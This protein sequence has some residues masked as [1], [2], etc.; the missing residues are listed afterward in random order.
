MER[1]L[2][3][4][5]SLTRDQREAVGLLQ[6]GTLLEY[7]DLMLYVHMAVL[8]NELF[9]PKIDAHTASLLSA[10]AFCSTFVLRPFGAFLFGY[11]GDHLGR[12]TTVIL[13]TM[14]M[15]LSCI[16]MANVPTYAQIG[17][18]ASW[19][20]TICRVVQG[21]SS[22]GEIVAAEVYLS[23]LIKPPAQYPAVGLMS[24]S[25][26]FGTMM[27]LGV[28]MIVFSLHLEWRLAFWFGATIALIGTV[29]RT[30]LRETPEFTEMK[31]ELKKNLEKARQEKSIQTALSS[32]EA[33]KQ[34]KATGK[35]KINQRSSMAFFLVYCAWPACF[36][37]SYVHCAGI[38]K[39]DFGYTAHEI[40]KQNF[41]VSIIQ[42]IG[43]LFFALL[44]YYVHPLKIIRYKGLILAPFFIVCP[45]LLFAINNGI[46]LFWIQSIVI[47]FGLA[48]APA[49]P[50]FIKTFPVF[51]RFT[52]TGFIYALTRAL[53]YVFTSFG[54]VYLTEMAGHWGLWG[55]M[56]P[57]NIAFLWGVYYFE[58]IAFPSGHSDHTVVFKNA[59]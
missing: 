9:F 28:A 17:I 8:L 54:L 47:F 46:Q 35:G 45:Y 49:M 20:V 2:K 11:I 6:I 15:S 27:G 44:S 43:Y 55:I 21:L 23:E 33:L 56:L 1:V 7:F 48:A 3:L 10:F 36:Y 40:I 51:K 41:F 13:T 30:R 14:M 58:K 53:M 34:A 57:T 50:I 19:A 42:C 16:V 4:L 31:S 26:A 52:Y 25:S 37:F 22:M 24:C 18:G 38:L 29:A 5:S 12:K 39:N 32:K 59:A